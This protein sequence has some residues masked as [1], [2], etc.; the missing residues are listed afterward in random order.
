MSDEKWEIVIDEVSPP[1][2]IYERLDRGR[3]LY[4]KWSVDNSWRQPKL[5]KMSSVRDEHGDVD[6]D[7]VTDARKAA[8]AQYRSQK[9]EEDTSDESDDQA[10]VTSSSGPLTL[11]K[12]FQEVLAVPGGKYPKRNDNHGAMRL[13]GERVREIHGDHLLFEDLRPGHYRQIWRTFARSYDEKQLGARM[14]ELT[15]QNLLAAANWLRDEGKI[16]HATTPPSRW[17]EKLKADWEKI[18]GEKPKPDRPRHTKEQYEAL[19]EHL[20]DEDKD[21]DPRCE[22]ALQLGAEYR[23]GQVVRS[24]RSDLDLSED[25]GIGFGTFRIH[26][27]RKKKGQL[28]YLTPEMRKTVDAALGEGGHL[29]EFETLYQEGEVD[30][31]PLWP[32][33]RLRKGKCVPREPFTQQS[34]DTIRGYFHDYEKQLGIE[35][36]DGRGWHGIR[37][38]AS[39]VSGDYTDNEEVRDALGGWQNRSGTRASYYEGDEKPPVLR[40]AAEVRRAMRGEVEKVNQDDADEDP[41]RRFLREN[42]I[43]EAKMGMALGLI[44][45]MAGES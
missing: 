14:A 13:A 3:A 42:G 25:A 36:V 18:V 10:S 29:H 23:L 22:L 40:R 9:K 4:I 37:R 41:R 38:S 33:G 6:P 28:V 5:K 32:G 8:L 24:G 39:D 27:R 20:A 15:V 44:E 16:G 2:H 12:G 11:K 26:G 31:Y 17:R 7:L 43:P 45:E 34:P 19:F 35:P 1:L 30:D 21:V